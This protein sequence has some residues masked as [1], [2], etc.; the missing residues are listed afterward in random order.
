MIV[1]MKS[2]ES[3]GMWDEENASMLCVLVAGASDVRASAM[4]DS[5]GCHEDVYPALCSTSKFI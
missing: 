3:D 5:R 1:M 2:K 4:R